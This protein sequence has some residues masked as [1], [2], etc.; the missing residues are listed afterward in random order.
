MSILENVKTFFVKKQTGNSIDVATKKACPNCW[1]VQE[2]DGQ[3][4]KK[5][6]AN[7]RKSV[8]SFIQKVVSKLD[9]I[10][11]KTDTFKCITCTQEAS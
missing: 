6:K 2:W 3:F 11:L 1:G 8:D 10:T 4:Y 7:N 5:I 9:K